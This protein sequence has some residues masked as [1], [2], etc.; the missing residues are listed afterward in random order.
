MSVTLDSVNIVRLDGIVGPSPIF[1][2]IAH[3]YTE[4]LTTPPNDPIISE[5]LQN[6]DVVV[7]TK[8][9]ITAAT[10]AA[11]PKLKLVAVLAIGYDHVALD[12]CKERGV[13]VCNVPAASNEAVAEHAIAMFFALRR[14]LIL[15]HELVV[16]GD[17]WVDKGSLSGSFATLPGTCSS[18]IMVVIGGGV[19]G[20]SFRLAS[21]YGLN[22]GGRQ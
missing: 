11:C 3:Q 12:A 22:V 17:E 13:S 18:E 20:T 15:L 14:N 6:A 9:P 16:K 21:S 4:Y 8:V 7:T 2:G 5:R 19:L 1:D 10:I